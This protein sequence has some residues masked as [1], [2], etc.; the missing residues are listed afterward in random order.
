MT[1]NKRNLKQWVE[2]EIHPSAEEIAEVFWC[3][4]SEEQAV[5]F[6]ALGS[7]DRLAFQLQA[8]RD[9]ACLEIKGRVAM[10]LIGEYGE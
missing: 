4:D 8:V 6:N 1:E 10:R 3:M 7:K 5:F 2:A 9:E